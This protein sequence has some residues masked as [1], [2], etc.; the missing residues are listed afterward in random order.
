MAG[1]ISGWYKFLNLNAMKYIFLIPFIFSTTLAMAQQPSSDL[2]N[3]NTEYYMM[4]NNHLLHFLSTG[5][6][7][8]VMSNA[9]L[10]NG[11]VLTS[12]GDMAGKKAAKQKLENGECIDV[13]GALKSCAILD[14]LLSAKIKSNDK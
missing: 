8:T 3:R 12:K 13:D 7:E 1:I 4:K 14:S 10:S 2:P 5:E 11:I 9:T 6:V